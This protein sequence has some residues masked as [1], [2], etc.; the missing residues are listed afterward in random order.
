MAVIVIMTAS[1]LGLPLP[2]EIALVSCGLI[3]YMARNPDLY[4]P[5]TPDAQGVDLATLA[6]VCFCAVILSDLLIF[7]LGK[8]FG[9]KI[10]QLPFTK[11]TL[12]EKNIR[13]VNFWYEKYGHWTC[14]VFRFTPG[15]RFPG[16]LSCGMMGVPVY[17]FLMIDGTAALISV[18]TQV[19]LVALYGDVIIDKLKQFKLYMFSAMAIAAVIFLIFK[20][21]KRYQLKK[22]SH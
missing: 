15:L 17:K 11:K 5:P 6:I 21:Y 14:G 22:Q 8:F 18:P 12:G 7:Y 3:A 20:L 16:H 4:P 13:R 2:E 19:V 1:S 9:Q 10:I